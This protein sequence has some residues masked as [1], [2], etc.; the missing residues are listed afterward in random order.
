MKAINMIFK[1]KDDLTR[2][3]GNKLILAST[4]MPV[5]CGSL[6]KESLHH[7]KEIKVK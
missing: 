5:Y 7:I 2:N 3:E 4:L 1:V 6:Q